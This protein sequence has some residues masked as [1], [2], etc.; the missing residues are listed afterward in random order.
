MIGFNVEIGK[1]TVSYYIVK[2]QIEGCLEKDL[3]FNNWEMVTV[4]QMEL[5]FDKNNFK[6]FLGSS[7]VNL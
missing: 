7:W 3:D 1:S 6:S 2:K 4:G 5:F